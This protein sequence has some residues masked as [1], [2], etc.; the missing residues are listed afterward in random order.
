MAR[1]SDAQ[2]EKLLAQKAQIEARLKD[3]D[4]REKAQQRKLD[5]RRKIVAGA[6]ALE[7]AEIDPTFGAEL[8]A[9]LNRLVKPHERFLFDFLDDRT[10]DVRPGAADGFASAAGANDLEETKKAETGS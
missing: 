7:H 5:T 3:L 8:A 10:P 1:L 4:A 6:I 9:L 2:R